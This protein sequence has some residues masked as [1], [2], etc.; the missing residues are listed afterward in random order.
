MEMIYAILHLSLTH[1]ILSI[2]D[3]MMNILNILP[4]P[5]NLTNT[6]SHSLDEGVEQPP[7]LPWTCGCLQL[8]WPLS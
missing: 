8:W 1:G 5:F 3:D 6:C 4:C 7:L 2:M